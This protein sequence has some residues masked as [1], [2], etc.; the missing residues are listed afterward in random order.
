MTEGLYVAYQAAHRLDRPKVFSV[1]GD[2][3]P[4]PE[5]PDRV[6]SLLSAPPSFDG[7]T[8]PECH[9]S[10]TSEELCPVHTLEPVQFLTDALAKW[11][12]DWPQEV[13]PG[14]LPA[15]VENARIPD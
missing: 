11:D 10:A 9:H 3:I 6:E 8:L 15:D 14:T 4:H 12:A 13:V 1:F 7:I 5:T 2:L